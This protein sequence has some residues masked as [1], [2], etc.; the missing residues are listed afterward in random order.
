[1]R[2]DD[3]QLPDLGSFELFLDTG[4]D[5]LLNGIAKKLDPHAE[6]TKSG[7]DDALRSHLIGLA[8][9]RLEPTAKTVRSKTPKATKPKN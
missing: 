5:K 3:G 8:A 9:K 1:M 7:D 6:A 4:D 2:R